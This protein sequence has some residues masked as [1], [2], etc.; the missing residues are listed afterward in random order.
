MGEQFS[1]RAVLGGMALEGANL[2]FCRRIRAEEIFGAA[3]GVPAV[4]NTHLL[5]VVAVRHG[6][7]RVCADEGA[8]GGTV[9]A[10]VSVQRVL[11][12]VSLP[13]ES[14]DVD[15]LRVALVWTSFAIFCDSWSDFNDFPFLS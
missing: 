2:L 13:W 10:V 5:T 4:G 14:V 6:Y 12:F 1:R 3:Q 8:D 11:S 9:C 7:G 15:Y